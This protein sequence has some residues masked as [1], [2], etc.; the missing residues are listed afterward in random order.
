M[1]LKN[2]KIIKK[3]ISTSLCTGWFQVIV[4]GYIVAN[5]QWDFISKNIIFIDN[6]NIDKQ[7]V[8][9]EIILAI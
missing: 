2:I 5:V 7:Q 9:K 3:S 6:K 4:K 1:N 8:K